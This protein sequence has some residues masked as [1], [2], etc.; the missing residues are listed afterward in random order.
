M[1]S[2]LVGLVLL[3][4]VQG[5][6]R[7][8]SYE[9][10]RDPAK[11]AT[12]MIR[13][14]MDPLDPS[15]KSPKL[16]GTPPQRWEFP[17]LVQGYV[18]TPGA[19]QY[20][21]RFRV[22]S[23]N[24]KEKNDQAP[25]V[26]R[27]LTALW[28]ENATRLQYD[29]PEQY[30]GSIVDVYLCWGGKAGGEQRFGVDFEGGRQ[31]SVNTIYFYDLPSFSDPVETAREVAHEYG[32]AI[33]PPI[34]GYEAPENWANG[35]LGEKLFMRWMRDAIAA[36]RLTTEDT[37]GAEAPQLDEWVRKNVDPLVI[38]SSQ[39]LPTPQLL[40]DPSAA[41]MDRY[42]GLAL[43]AATILPD[44]VFGRSMLL[45]SSTD[46]KDYPEAIALAAEE[47]A[48]YTLRIPTYL[49]G[50]TLWIPVTKAKIKGAKILRFMGK[51]A[52]I[53]PTAADVVVTNPEVR[54]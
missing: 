34:G 5:D 30:N 39:A 25:Q 40:N 29:H 16:F 20:G 31:K 23:Q 3:G 53:Q 1:V 14:E 33:L 12:A 28:D 38:K 41:G 52:K 9:V 47:P 8:S 49:R 35:Y 6:R 4:Q 36:G 19:A 13:T 46:A 54:N 10:T 50:K 18:R 21:L 32:H 11:G 51:W 44:A 42:I 43:Y 45:T 37:M 26:A 22:Y 27:M 24:R 48:E 17:W 15:K 2:S 7:I